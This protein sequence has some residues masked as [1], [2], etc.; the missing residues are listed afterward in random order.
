MS[1]AAAH[2]ISDRGRQKGGIPVLPDDLLR[3]ITKNLR[4]LP[5]DEL[6]VTIP[7]DDEEH[8]RRD[9]Q[10]LL[11]AVTLF[12]DLLFALPEFTK[13]RLKRAPECGD[14]EC[15]VNQRKGCQLKE[16]TH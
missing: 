9:V 6:Y 7:V 5:V 8:D 15:L 13:D 4:P 12:S 11:K 14:D 3:G 16:M 1:E 2:L 10:V